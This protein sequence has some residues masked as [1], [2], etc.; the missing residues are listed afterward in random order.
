MLIL[1]LKFTITADTTSIII[2][3]RY[4]YTIS[5][6]FF[7]MDIFPKNNYVIDKNINMK[8]YALSLKTVSINQQIFKMYYSVTYKY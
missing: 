1:F 5:F 7:F 3:T 2:H 8:Y 4:R 6:F